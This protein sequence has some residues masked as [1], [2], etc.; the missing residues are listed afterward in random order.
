MTEKRVTAISLEEEHGDIRLVV[1]C[2][3]RGQLFI[4]LRRNPYRLTNPHRKPIQAATSLLALSARMVFLD[5]R[6]CGLSDRAA[7]LLWMDGLPARAPTAMNDRKRDIGLCG[8]HTWL[9]KRGGVAQ[10]AGGTR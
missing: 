10:W 2:G 1:R 7:T 4:G 3:L 9:R 5:Q 8:R 6:V